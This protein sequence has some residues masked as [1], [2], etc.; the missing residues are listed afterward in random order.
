MLTVAFQPRAVDD[1]LHLLRAPSS[2]V[3]H[4][5]GWASRVPH[6][7]Q[8]PADLVA[9]ADAAD[10]LFFDGDDLNAASFT[11]VVAFLAAQR[12]G[13]L[14]LCAVKYRTEVDQLL[15]SWT[16]P[17]TLTAGH[18]TLHIVA[19]S[20]SD[21]A[22]VAVPLRYACIDPDTTSD[23][24]HARY[25]QLGAWGLAL[26]QGTTVAALGGGAVVAAEYR[27]SLLLARTV[28][29][30]VF[31]PLSRPP[32]EACA[33]VGGDIEE[34]DALRRPDDRRLVRHC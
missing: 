32:G 30:H 7:T 1:P 16:T 8:L 14:T 31:P 20:S 11:K 4:V 25:A 9:L 24:S 13:D 27:A 17:T 34:A 29:W 2:R 5:K 6:D 26:T 21:R 3:L 15:T 22:A 23:S 19:P 28:V 33:L 12:D 10:V 18:E